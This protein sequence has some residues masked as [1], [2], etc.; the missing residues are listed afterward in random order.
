MFAEFIKRAFDGDLSAT[1]EEAYQKP[2]E[3]PRSGVECRTNLVRGAIIEDAS[4]ESSRGPLF[5]TY[6]V[7]SSL[8]TNPRAHQVAMMMM[9]NTA[10]LSC[11]SAVAAGGRFL[12]T[13]SAAPASGNAE[14]I[15]H[16]SSPPLE[17]RRKEW[18]GGR[19]ELGR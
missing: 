11:S 10:D 16:S 12:P 2:E 17:R 15:P 9:S 7:M 13:S 1:K 5:V 18:E 4:H 6:E 19:S 3:A 8:T 14:W